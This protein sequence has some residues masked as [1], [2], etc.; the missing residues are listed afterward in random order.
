M[1]DLR[2][3]Q[4]EPLDRI[5]AGSGMRCLC[6]SEEFMQFPLQLRILGR[7]NDASVSQ[8]A[9]GFSGNL[10]NPL[11]GRLFGCHANFVHAICRIFHKVHISCACWRL[12][13]GCVVAGIPTVARSVYQPANPSCNRVR[14][15]IKSLSH[16]IGCRADSLGQRFREVVYGLRCRPSKVVHD[17]DCRTRNIVGNLRHRTNDQ[18]NRRKRGPDYGTILG[19][20]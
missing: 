12:A 15:V 20:N 5:V 10:L 17:L 8:F 2:G 9:L 16:I 6:A 13:H 11:C 3:C 1:S 4:R 19:T 7:L 14:G 18:P